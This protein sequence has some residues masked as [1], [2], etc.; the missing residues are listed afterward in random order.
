MR[1]RF[2]AALLALTGWAA[3]AQFLGYVSPQSVNSVV[4]NAVSCTGSPQLFITGTAPAPASFANLGQTQHWLTIATTGSPTFVFAEIDGI[5]AQGVVYRMSDVLNL[6][7]FRT[8]ATVQASG[9]FPQIQIQ[10]KCATGGHFTAS[11]AGSSSSVGPNTGAYQMAQIGKVIAAGSPAGSGF[12]ETLLQ[13]PFG[14]TAG[15]LIFQY[16][17]TGPTGSLLTVSC[18]GNAYNSI[19]YNFAISPAN[20]ITFFTVPPN[21]CPQVQIDYS[22]GGASG[23][24]W[25]LEYDFTQPGFPAGQSVYNPIQLGVAAITEPATGTSALSN[26]IVTGS[27]KNATLDFSCTAGPVTV[28]VQTYDANIAIGTPTTATIVS[29][30]SAVAAAT[31][32]QLYIGSDGNPGASNGTISATANIRFPQRAIAFSFTNAGGAGTCT[33]QLYLNY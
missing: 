2:L 13:A 15:T 5:D 19:S 6:A 8:S 27:A 26:A 14:N 29:P 22:A 30:L 9:Y 21:S 10:V 12:E 18:L 33:A 25:N 17:G 3:Q 32:T 11:Y 23:A 4:A 20:G 7:S 28:N 24:T 1:T 16:N 31:K